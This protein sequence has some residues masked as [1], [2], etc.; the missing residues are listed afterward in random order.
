M[1]VFCGAHDASD[2]IVIEESIQSWTG[3]Y[4][5][6]SFSSSSLLLALFLAYILVAI[7]SNKI[8]LGYA[9]EVIPHPAGFEKRTFPTAAK[10]TGDRANGGKIPTV[11]L[12]SSFI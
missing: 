5:T 3:E 6:V 11:C 10:F 4:G 8:I 9:W 12:L 1:Y 7:T 2:Q